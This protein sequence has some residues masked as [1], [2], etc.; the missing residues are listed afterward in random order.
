MLPDAGVTTASTIKSGA[1]PVKFSAPTPGV[2]STEEKTLGA[3]PEIEILP[4]STVIT[5]LDVPSS[6]AK[7]A[8]ENGA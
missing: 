7:G 8:P 4:V 1:K 3:N 5:G 6:D 2:T